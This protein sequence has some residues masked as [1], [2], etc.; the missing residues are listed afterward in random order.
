MDGACVGFVV[1]FLVAWAVIA[2]F[3]NY[4]RRKDFMPLLITG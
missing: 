2:I 1:A 4:I 3:M